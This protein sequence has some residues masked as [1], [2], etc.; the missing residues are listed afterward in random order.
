MREKT[1]IDLEET[2]EVLDE[3][4]VK[5]WLEHGTLLGAIRDG[6]II[7]WDDEIDLGMMED[8]WEKLLYSLS[9]LKERGFEVWVNE[10]KISENISK[11]GAGI[12]RSGY[13]INFSVYQIKGEKAF[14]IKDEQVN[15]VSRSLKILY[16]FLQ[17]YTP[18]VKKKWK[19]FVKFAKTCI[20]PFPSPVKDKLSDVVFNVWKRSGLEFFLWAAPKRYFD[21]LDTTEFYGMTFNTPSDVENYLKHHYGDDWRTPRR[22]WGFETKLQEVDFKHEM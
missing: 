13:P 9:E 19:P 15:L 14:R 11:K 22:E 16:Y 3:F 4:E 1:V 10:Y 7:E 21:N 6:K 18:Y 12:Q 8:D 5:F 17:S 2:K 20:S